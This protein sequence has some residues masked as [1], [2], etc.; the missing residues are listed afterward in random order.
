MNRIII[1]SLIALAI[2]VSILVYELSVSSSNNT[3]NIETNTQIERYL[4]LHKTTI[5][6]STKASFSFN[7]SQSSNTI[8]VDNFTYSQ[9]IN[10]SQN[11]GTM[12]KINVIVSSLPT[13]R[14]SPGIST[15]T[16][17]KNTQLIGSFNNT[18]LNINAEGHLIALE[19]YGKNDTIIFENGILFYSS[20][21][22]GIVVEVRNNTYVIK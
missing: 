9:I 13:I 17:T 2:V 3:N 15:Y 14:I 7:L 20:S 10:F 1:F 4:I 21:M 22:P 12:W 6:N 8:L 19:I 18:V 11:P 16:A 5:I